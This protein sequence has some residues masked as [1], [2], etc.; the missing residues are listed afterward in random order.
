M[1]CLCLVFSAKS[2]TKIILVL[3][4]IVLSFLPLMGT[5]IVNIYIICIIIEQAVVTKRKPCFKPILTIG[6][7]CWIY[8]LSHVPAY[9]FS[10]LWFAGVYEVA[11][12]WL[13]VFWNCAVSINSVT[14][15]IVY[16]VTNRRYRSYVLRCFGGVFRVFHVIQNTINNAKQHAINHAD[17]DA[18]N[19]ATQNVINNAAQ[20]AINNAALKAITNTA[21]GSS[22]D[23]ALIVINNAAEDAV[24]NTIQD[25][26]NNTTEVVIGNANAINSATEDAIDNSIQNAINNANEDA[27]NKSTDTINNA[28]DTIN[29]AADNVTEDASHD[30]INPQICINNI[31]LEDVIRL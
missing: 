26:V 6:C 4:T 17:L 31:F 30:N 9:V 22:T 1:S 19:N 8:A 3:E 15:P 27:F 16:F 25:D 12:T 24:I 10:I 23:S 21:Q 7:V 13:T 11:P 5:F 2:H 29:N 18:I 14:N 28:T 20:D